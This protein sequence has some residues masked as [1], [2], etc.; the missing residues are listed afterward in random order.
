M[1]E[2]EHGASLS[3]AVDGIVLAAGRGERI[4]RPKAELELGGQTFLEHALAALLGGGCRS[5]VV[6]VADQREVLVTGP[7]DD[8]VYVRNPDP[9]SEQVDSLRIGLKALPVD[10]A[11]AMVLPVDVPA[12]RPET[13]AALI[14]AFDRE[15]CVIVRPVHDG[16]PGHPTL[17]ARPLFPELCTPGLPRGAE[18]IVELHA[19]GT[20]DVVVDDAGVLL[21]V[22]TPADLRRLVEGA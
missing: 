3:A 13:V 10:T 14:Q 20:R 11:A 12:V 9:D 5:V 18:S 6:V 19:A 2:R 7:A 1:A 16:R 8:V 21:D 17:F 4:G 22:D 15:D